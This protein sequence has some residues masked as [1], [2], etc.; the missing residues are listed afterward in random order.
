MVL[1]HGRRRHARVQRHSRVRLAPIATRVE[2]PATPLGSTGTATSIPIDEKS[3]SIEESD[4]R[5][6]RLVGHGLELLNAKTSDF[7]CI[8]PSYLRLNLV[9]INTVNSC[10]KTTR[11]YFLIIKPHTIN[12]EREDKE[13]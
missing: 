7:C 5:R 1:L 13:R 9:S 11:F 4:H 3:E 2:I 6:T 10:V 8:V 12:R